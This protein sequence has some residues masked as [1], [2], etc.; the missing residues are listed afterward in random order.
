[1]SKFSPFDA[2]NKSNSLTHLSQNETLQGAKCIK[3]YDSLILHHT[4]THVICEI[5]L[6]NF[7]KVTNL[8]NSGYTDKLYDGFK[9]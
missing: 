5:K 1:M 3:V 4:L 9:R 8:L 7:L 2:E 6:C